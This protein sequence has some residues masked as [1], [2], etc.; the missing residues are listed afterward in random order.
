MQSVTQTA[1]VESASLRAGG[2]PGGLMA[3]FMLF[4]GIMV[5]LRPNSV[6]RF[7]LF[8]VYIGL[9]LWAGFFLRERGMRAFSPLR[10]GFAAT[11]GDN[12]NLMEPGESTMRV[13]KSILAVLAGIIVDVILSIGTDALLHA[14]GITPALGR[15]F[16]DNLLVLATAYRTAYGVA[17]GYLT[18]RLAPDRP[19]Q[20]ALAGGFLG[21]VLGTLG[22]VLT[23]NKGPEFGPHWYPLALIV[24]ALPCAWMGGALRRGKPSGG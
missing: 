16:P 15:R 22:A 5:D 17:G 18:A 14:I 8:P 7:H 21:L 10:V 3:W 20:H 12:L 9:L 19:M 24:L 4:G 6:P 23:W 2:I 1:P 11:D 13:L